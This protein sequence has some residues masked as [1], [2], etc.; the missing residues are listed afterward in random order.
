[1][2]YCTTSYKEFLDTGVTY[3]PLKQTGPP[4][5]TFLAINPYMLLNRCGARSE[6]GFPVDYKDG[7]IFD[8]CKVKWGVLRWM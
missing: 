6:W 7:Q 8:M 2:G 3:L 4:V 5:C 1:M